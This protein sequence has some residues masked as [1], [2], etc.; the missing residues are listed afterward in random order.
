MIN[1]SL[2]SNEG[3]TTQNTRYLQA[4]LP[5][6]ERHVRYSRHL[7]FQHRRTSL[8]LRSRL[9]IH[10][11][12]RSPKNN[13]RQTENKSAV[14]NSDL[15][16]VRFFKKTS[17]LSIHL[18]IYI[19]FNYSNSSLSSQCSKQFK[20]FFKFIPRNTKCITFSYC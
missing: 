10:T 11:T 15:H 2:S 3:L 8:N 19:A 9:V 20:C 1:R 12:I 5:V 13:R 18:Y 6:T 17:P 16:S 14:S 4:S 7:S